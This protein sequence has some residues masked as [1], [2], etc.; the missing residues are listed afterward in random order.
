M[1]NWTL[2]PQDVQRL[3]E[4]EATERTEAEYASRL[5]TATGVQRLYLRFECWFRIRRAVR[6]SLRPGPLR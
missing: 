1:P 3:I 6:A 4:A 2:G 5:Q